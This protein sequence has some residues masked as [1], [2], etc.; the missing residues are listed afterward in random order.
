MLRIVQQ[1]LLFHVKVCFPVL[2][3]VLKQ[4]FSGVFPGKFT[5]RH[6]VVLLE[7]RAK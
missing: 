1:M 7:G 6:L 3:A 4:I 5:R 2:R